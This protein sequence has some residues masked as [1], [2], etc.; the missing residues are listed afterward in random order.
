MPGWL[1]ADIQYVGHTTSKI[2]S[3]R[4]KSSSQGLL[5]PS[6][7][8]EITLVVLVDKKVARKLQAKAQDLEATVIIHAEHGLDHFIAVN[9]TLRK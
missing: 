5:L 1:S 8:V 2:L 3:I 7:K 4:L 9:A 6:E